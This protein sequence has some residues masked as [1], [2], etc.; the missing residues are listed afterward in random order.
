MSH[1]KPPTVSLSLT[2]RCADVASALDFYAK[3]FGAVESFRLSAPDGSIAHAEFDIGDTH[4][5]ISG[6]SPEWLAHA[7]PEGT[8]ASCLFAIDSED[9]DRAYAQ[10]IAAG[11]TSVAAPEDHFWGSR[12]AIVRDPFGYRWCFGQKT[13]DITPE[14][15][16][17]RAKELFGA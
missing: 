8:T 6:E 9:C 3:A 12:D 11:A 17:R 10:A 5:F 13:E 2:V 7:M 16:A 4:L 14:E 15:I 1:K